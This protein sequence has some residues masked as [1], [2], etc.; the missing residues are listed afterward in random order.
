[1]PK[2]ALP[3]IMEMRKPLSVSPMPRLPPAVM[4]GVKKV[5]P[6]STTIAAH[7]PCTFLSFGT[8]LREYSESSAWTFFSFSSLIVT[9]LSVCDTRWARIDVSSFII[10]YPHY[11]I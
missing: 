10:R 6:T 5:K 2:N 1:M 9:S 8:A 4:L 11:I 7:M 3:T